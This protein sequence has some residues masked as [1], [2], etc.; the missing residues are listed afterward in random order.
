VS[1]TRLKLRGGPHGAKIEGEIGGKPLTGVYH[2]EMVADVH[3][4]IRAT[5]SQYVEVDIDIE[6]VVETKGKIWLAVR[7]PR[8]VG[9]SADG[10]REIA[11]TTLFTVEGK[12]LA[13]ALL[14]ASV[15]AEGWMG[16]SS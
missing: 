6:S 12:N 5:I 9:E 14:A 7:E 10:I 13:A 3:D 1:T 8:V 15:K 11:L 2:I 4:V 16:D